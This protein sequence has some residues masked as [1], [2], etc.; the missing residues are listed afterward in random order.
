MNRGGGAVSMFRGLLRFFGEDGM[1]PVG[2]R[3][4]SGWEGRVDPEVGA[5]ACRSTE[6]HSDDFHNC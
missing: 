6:S 4:G 5:R 1:D 3:F 2:E